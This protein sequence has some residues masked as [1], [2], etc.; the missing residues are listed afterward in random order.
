[1]SG[2]SGLFGNERVIL[3]V[4]I[5]DDDRE[6][7]DMINRRGL[8]YPT[9]LLFTLVHV[10]YSMFNL[11][12]SSDLEGSLVAINNQKRPLVDINRQHWKSSDIFED[13]FHRCS[14]CA[15]YDEPVFLGYH[16]S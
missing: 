15:K 3:D 4:E 9:S 1:M 6:Y 12:I 13:I 7:F 5:A 8:T 14:E 10:G 11:C 16:N 2:V